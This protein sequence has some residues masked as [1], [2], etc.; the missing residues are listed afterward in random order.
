[1]SVVKKRQP[2]KVMVFGVFDRLHAGHLYF[3]KQAARQGEVVA[4]VARESSV[5]RLKNKKSAQGEKERMRELKKTGLVEDA[6][7]GDK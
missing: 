6:I 7:L 4:V 5:Q 2:S 3:L 1:M